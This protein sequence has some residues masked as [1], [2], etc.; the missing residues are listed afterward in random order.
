MQFRFAFALKKFGFCLVVPFITAVFENPVFAAPAPQAVAMPALVDWNYAFADDDLEETWSWAARLEAGN[1]GPFEARVAFH[2]AGA[3]EHLLLRVH[4][5]GKATAFSFWRV[6]GARVTPLGEPQVNLAGVRDGQLTI[7]RSAWRMRALWNG[8]VILSAFGPFAGGKI[9]TAALGA[10]FYEP[11]LQPTEPVIKQDDFM[12]AQGPQD[13]SV[14]PDEI[15]GVGLPK[16][17]KVT[18]VAAPVKQSSSEW[19]VVSGSWKTS[20][21]M[22]TRVRFDSS[23]NPN[24]FVYRAESKA[25]GGAISAV[26][27]WFWSDYS[28]AVALRPMLKNPDAP[29]VA[30]VAAYGQTNGLS[31]VGEVDFRSGRASLRQ[32]SEVLAQSAPF[33]CAPN[34]WHRVFLD[35]GPGT[36]RLLVDGVERLRVASPASPAGWQSRALA[37]G[38]AALRA[39][40]GGGNFVDFDDVRI[41]ASDALSDD[42]SLSSGG[43]WDDLSGE[44]QT[45]KADGARSA[46]RVKVSAGP[47]ISLTGDAGREEGLIEASFESGN[48]PRPKAISPSAGMAFGMRD[49]KNYFIA[50]ERA[51]MLEIVEFTNGVGSI[52]ASELNKSLRKAG[53]PVPQLSVEWRDG[54]ITLRS[55]DAVATVT[56]SAIPAGRVGLWADGPT[57]ELAATSFRVLALPPGIGEPPLPDRFQKDRLMRS[58]ASNAAAWRNISDNSALKAR[59]MLLAQGGS[60]TTGREQIF[61]HTGDFFS[62]AELTAPV[63]DIAS[64]ARLTLHLRD[65]LSDDA[66]F[67]PIPQKGLQLVKTPQDDGK[68]A[69]PG[70]ARLEIEREGDNWQF[71]LY[72]GETLVKTAS[73]PRVPGDDKGEKSRPSL[74]FVR[75]LVGDEQVALRV[76]LDGKMLFSETAPASSSGTKIVMRLLNIAPVIANFESGQPVKVAANA[77]SL[78]D[79][80][81]E[82]ASRLDYTFTGAPTDWFAARGRWEVAERWTCQ[83]Q[84]GFFRGDNAVS[85]TLWSRF[86]TK[87]DW[88]LEAYVATP[89]DQTRGERNP[90]DLN[91]TVGADGR[92]LDSGYSFVFAPRGGAEHLIL[93]GADVVLKTPSIMPSVTGSI[94]QDW[95]YIRLERRA[96]PQGLRFRWVVNGKE[97]AS[98]LDTKTPPDAFDKPGRFAFWT[99]DFGLSIARVRLWHAG[100]ETAPDAGAENVGELL[101]ASPKT[102]NALGEWSPRR[103]DVLHTSARFENVSDGKNSALRVTNPQS[104]GDWT[105]FV[106]R[107]QLDAA[108][109]PVLK[110]DYRVPQNVFLNLYVKSGGRW[111]EI[112]FT[113]DQ[114]RAALTAVAVDAELRLGK[115]EGVSADNQWHSA[116]FDLHKALIK[117]GLPAQVESIAFAAP[118]RGYL[119]AGIG[120]NHQGATYELRD[121]QAAKSAATTV[122]AVR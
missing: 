97:I 64:G 57:G 89:M 49:E 10:K 76:A 39:T 28:V 36:I 9:G 46:G 56:V 37:Q 30:G 47:A 43:R 40:T 107:G 25:S 13:A 122:A 65:N 15:L 104:G 72:E 82:T 67:K 54:V 86:S 50:R 58:W 70:G 118:E 59:F 121:F 95:Y 6:A 63:P 52:L 110:F 53:S 22:D 51:G 100:L 33:S 31:L 73:A 45:R 117:L 29:L 79:T 68:T 16:L 83:P 17:A 4:N 105:L 75:R 94:H 93:R 55:K 77:L 78:E 5:D 103:D 1:A 119:R 23:L 120:G 7:Q 91:L 99:H 69:R 80:V 8:R 60:K 74:R 20:T 102:P 85:P 101:A 92:D 2:Y 44:W 112:G 71:K 98:Y 24:P 113:G 62:D 61:M 87:G 108:T 38:E 84:F 106:T 19:R 88:T 11:R 26:G 34:Q 18:P 90:Q 114:A 116:S 81:A 41:A 42:F 115:I 27:K 14:P 3:Q 21:M 111:R 109:R 96:T 32:G 48:A 35:P 12:T 66:G